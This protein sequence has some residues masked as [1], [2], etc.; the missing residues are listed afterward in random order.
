[1]NSSFV[2]MAFANNKKPIPPSNN[3]PDIIHFFEYLFPKIPVTGPK[4]SDQIEITN[5]RKPVWKAV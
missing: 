1:M 5:W 3:A 2:V 4:T